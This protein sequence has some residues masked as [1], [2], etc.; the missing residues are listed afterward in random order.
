MCGCFGNM[1]TCIYYVFV[2]FHLCIFILFMLLFNFVS[3][4]FL[5][6]C[7][8][9]S[10]YSVFI[11]PTGTLWLPGLR[12]FC[13]FSSVVRQMPEYN[14]QRWG[15]GHTLPKLI[16]LFCVL[17]VCNCVLYYCHR[18]STQLQL[19][20]IYISLS[21]YLNFICLFFKTPANYDFCVTAALIAVIPTTR[22]S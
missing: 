11:V 9:C 8:F 10:V 12:V 1:C 19:T 13:A 18:V 2:L 16:V 7:M 17:F 3:Y 21:L 4:I 14:S 15:T 5:L 6:L 20:N 22:D